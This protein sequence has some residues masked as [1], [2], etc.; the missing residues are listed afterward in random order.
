MQLG[1]QISTLVP[2]PSECSL[3]FERAL[4]P[5]LLCLQSSMVRCPVVVRAS[6][7]RT[8]STSTFTIPLNSALIPSLSVHSTLF[9]HPF[10]PCSCPA[11]CSSSTCLESRSS[12]SLSRCPAHPSPRVLVTCETSP[13]LHSLQSTSRTFRTRISNLISLHAEN[14]TTL[15]RR[16][17]RTQLR[18]KVV[19][20][21]TML[22][23]ASFCALIVDVVASGF[24]RPTH[25]RASRD[26]THSHIQER[27]SQSNIRLK[28]K[29][30]PA[31]ADPARGEHAESAPGS[32]GP[33][34]PCHAGTSERF[35]AQVVISSSGSRA[36]RW[37]EKRKM[38]S[39]VSH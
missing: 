9:P 29:K 24:L 37:A 6:I 12:R 3:R 4:H 39:P 17:S 36:S 16:C 13:S 25:C 18:P 35:P 15:I 34:G 38:L 1:Y 26:H 20:R 22:R 28:E 21:P 31:R 14:C 30:A 5:I 8:R 2:A 10:E 11:A 7:Q 23:L 33:L 32:S 27:R 19:I